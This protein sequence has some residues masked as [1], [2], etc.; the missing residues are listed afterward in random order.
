MGETEQGLVDDHP[1]D[2]EDDVETLPDEA[3]GD[4]EQD[5]GIDVKTDEVETEDTEAE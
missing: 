4:D 3:P 2:A 5:V 1:E